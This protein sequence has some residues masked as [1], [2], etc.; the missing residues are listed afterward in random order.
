MYSFSFTDSTLPRT[1]RARMGMRTMA[2]A[3]TTLVMLGL[4]MT[5]IT[6]ARRK[7]GKASITSMSRMI[8]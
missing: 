3:S 8:S 5:I 2:R 4:R 6:M 1:M 7:I